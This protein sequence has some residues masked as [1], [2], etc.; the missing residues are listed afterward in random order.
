MIRRELAIF[1]VVGSL[2]VVVDF[3]TYHGL[4]WTGALDIGA[5]KAI[6][7]LTGTVFAYFANRIWTFG[8]KE[9]ASGSVLRF[10]LLYAVTMG[11]NVV[12]NA[13]VIA[14]PIKVSWQFQLAFLMATGTSAVLNFIGMKLFV[15]KKN[16]IGEVA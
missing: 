3:L 5:A 1:L 15:F 4:L 14:L 16:Y 11:A 12:I 13:F 2:T 8:D 7:F 6:G 10:A 9:P